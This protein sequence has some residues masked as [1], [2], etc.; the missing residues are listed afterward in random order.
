[1]CD[2]CAHT[3]AVVCCGVLTRVLWCAVV[4][5]HACCG[6]L[7]CA[8]TRA[9]IMNVLFVLLAARAVCCW[10]NMLPFTHMLDVCADTCVVF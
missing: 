9:D 10:V 5:S 7:W 6:V 3:R 4:C 2:W 8:H 1:M